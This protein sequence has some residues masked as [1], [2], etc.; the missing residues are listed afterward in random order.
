MGGGEF[1]HRF[2]R[3]CQLLEHYFPQ[4][5]DSRRIRLRSLQ[6]VQER[7]QTLQSGEDP[8]PLGVVELRHGGRTISEIF[9]KEELG[10]RSLSHRHGP[11]ILGS[12]F[13]LAFSMVCH[14]CLH[15]SHW[16]DTVFSPRPY[17]TAYPCG[18]IFPH[19]GQRTELLAMGLE[20]PRIMRRSSRKRYWEKPSVKID[21]L[22][23]SLRRL[24]DARARNGW[25]SGISGRW[26]PVQT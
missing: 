2:L 19:F 14:A 15:E 18:T 24:A 1:L 8:G 4:M 5:F 23:L 12:G 22:L 3:G 13:G 21:G 20:N 7:M 26:H 16:Y 11:E 6:L 25:L 9:R 17:C 10:W